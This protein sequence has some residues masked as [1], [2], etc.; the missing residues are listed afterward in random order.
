MLLKSLCMGSDFDE[1]LRFIKKKY[2]FVNEFI[3]EQVKDKILP[4]IPLQEASLHYF[5]AGGK[6]LRPVMMLLA[7]SAVTN[8]IDF[9]KLSSVEEKTL[10]AAATVEIIHTMTL[11]HDDIM[12]N[13]AWRRGVPSVHTKWDLNTAILAGD[14]LIGLGFELLYGVKASSTTI[15]HVVHELGKTFREICEGQQQ[16]MSFETL[17]V[18]DLNLEQIFDMQLKKTGLLFMFA[19]ETG[20][21][22]GLDDPNH[23]LVKQ[24]REYAR[25]A[26][27]AFQ[28]QDDILGLIADEEKLG[29]PVGSDIREGKK[30]IP[31]IHAYQNAS[32]EQREVLNKAFLNP[33]ASK[34]EVQAFLDV[35]EK[36][37]S[38]EYAKQ[39]SI[40]FAKKAVQALQATGLNN[41]ALS[42]MQAFPEFMIQR[43]W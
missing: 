15:L 29:K 4:P 1:L 42:L 16:D 9:D 34:Q 2:R 18:T 23:S 39:L 25:N 30:T 43:E 33:N 17:P 14:A 20:A 31:I 37:G 27:I 32:H 12:D 10:P 22:I 5:L 41:Q 24:F 8:D 7:S 35:L 19:V 21:I 28:I 38:I 13:D 36:L 3:I 11:I 6:G 26:G 40:D